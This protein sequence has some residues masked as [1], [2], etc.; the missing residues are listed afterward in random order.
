MAGLGAKLFASFTKLTAAD[1][2]GYLADQSIMRFATSV[3]RDAAFGGAGEPTLAEG[4]TCYLDDTNVLQSYTGSA[5]VEIASSLGSSPRG[6]MGYAISTAN[7]SLTTSDVDI[8]GMSVTFT[9]VTGRLYRATFNGFYQKST[10]SRVFLSL[11]DGSNVGQ[12]STMQS[13]ASGDFDYFTAVFLFTASAG[14]ITRKMRASTELGTATIFGVPA[15]G[16]TYSFT[17]EDIGAS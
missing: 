14:S 16:R 15:D 8:T 13:T 5:W 3:A 10:T 4:M 11:T 7:T 9:A 2:N 1:V 6:I 12:N 17:I